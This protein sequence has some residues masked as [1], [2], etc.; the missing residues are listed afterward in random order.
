L[1]GDEGANV[2]SLIGVIGADFVIPQ[3]MVG[4]ALVIRFHQTEREALR[5]IANLG[6]GK[7]SMAHGVG[8]YDLK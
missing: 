3:P 4:R 8:V 2:I 6:N 5:A 1:C 7:Q